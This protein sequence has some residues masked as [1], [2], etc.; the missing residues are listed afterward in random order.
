MSTPRTSGS[1]RA[2]ETAAA[3]MAAWRLRICA[4]S[5]ALRGAVPPAVPARPPPNCTA[6]LL[7][8]LLCT[9][10]QSDESCKERSHALA[11]V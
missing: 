1:F 9:G 10:A 5:T 7:L 3:F 2:A 11:N 6:L 4:S 8:S